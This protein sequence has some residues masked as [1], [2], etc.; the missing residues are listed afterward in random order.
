MLG[1]N[2]AA[3]LLGGSQLTT[4]FIIQTLHSAPPALVQSVVPL[5]WAPWESSQPTV[6]LLKQGF[7]PITHSLVQHGSIVK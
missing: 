5:P 3:L 6:D 1:L 2:Y 4:S 7:H